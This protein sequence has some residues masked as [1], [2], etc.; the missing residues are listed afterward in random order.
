M[1]QT[2]MVPR[3]KILSPPFILYNQTQGFKPTTGSGVVPR[4]GSRTWRKVLPLPLASSYLS[5][6]MRERTLV[7]SSVKSQNSICL[8]G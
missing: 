2:R 8:L 4:V 6:Q 7:F 1:E 5:L 3:G